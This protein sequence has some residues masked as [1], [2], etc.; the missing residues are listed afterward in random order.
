[1]TIPE[2]NICSLK[3]FFIK[4]NIFLLY[5]CLLKFSRVNGNEVALYL[6]HVPFSFYKCA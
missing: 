2:P 6:D 4:Y 3:H 5:L 1:M